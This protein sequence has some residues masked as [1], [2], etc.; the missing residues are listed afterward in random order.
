MNR[1]TFLQTLAAGAG[2]LALTGAGAATPGFRLHYMLASS[3]YGNLPLASILPEVKKT[4]ASSLDLWPK[5]HGTQREEIDAL[6]HE[7][8]AELLQEQGLSLGCITRFDL[9]PF[10]LGDE[11]GVAK[12]FGAKL[13]V[14][15]ASGNAKLTG[16]ELKAEVKSF[17]EKMQPFAAQAAE[18]GVTI[19]IENHAGT[20]AYTPDSLRW[21]AE[22]AGPGLGIALAPYHLPQDA[23]QLAQLLRN[24]AP[25]LSLFYAWEYGMGCMKPMPKEEELQQLPG[26]G[27][28]DFRPLLAALAEVQFAGPTEIFMHPTPRGIPI[29]E[30]APQVTA[31]IA[32]SRAYLDGLLA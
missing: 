22:Y 8:F 19:A 14:T 2:G 21:L 18:A 24:V 11:I 16:G 25:R 6:G 5:P 27:H 4:G 10:R 26:R 3:M 12:K 23:A 32:R 1:R 31:E 28:F 17:V 15:G 20:T 29:L 13:L 7:K 9:G 30:T